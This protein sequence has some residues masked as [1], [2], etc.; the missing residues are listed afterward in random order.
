MLKVFKIIAGKF[1]DL[2]ENKTDLKSKEKYIAY[3]N[4]NFTF[5]L[6]WKKIKSVR[7]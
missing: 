3:T 2:A 7:T 6:F 4:H 5:I 1:F